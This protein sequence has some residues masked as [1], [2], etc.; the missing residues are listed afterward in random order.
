MKP[1]DA[2]GT[3][4]GNGLWNAIASPRRASAASGLH[5]LT[6]KD[7]GVVV[8][9]FSGEAVYLIFAMTPEKVLRMKPQKI[10]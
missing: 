10:L 2:E 6:F 3:C 7:A 4:I 1:S 5:R 9:R 8:E